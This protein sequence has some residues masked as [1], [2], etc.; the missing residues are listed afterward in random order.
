MDGDKIK[1]KAELKIKVG[2]K[3]HKPSSK[4]GLATWNI[5]LYYKKNKKVPFKISGA[6]NVATSSVKSG[7]T[8]AFKEKD[9]ASNPKVIIEFTDSDIISCDDDGKLNE[10]ITVMLSAKVH[11]AFVDLKMTDLH[12]ALE[13]E[14]GNWNG[15]SKK[16]SVTGDGKKKKKNHVA[17]KASVKAATK[18][19]DDNTS[20]EDDSKSTLTS[21]SPSSSS[22]SSSSND[23][24]TSS[25]AAAAAAPITKVQN[26][27]TGMGIAHVCYDMQGTSL[28]QVNFLIS[29]SSPK[30]PAPHAPSKLDGALTRLSVAFTLDGKPTP[31]QRQQ[32]YHAPQSLFEDNVWSFIQKEGIANVGGILAF[33]EI[34]CEKGV[35]K[36]NLQAQV[37]G[38][39]NGES[40]DIKS[41]FP[42]AAA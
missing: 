35:I 32:V 33:P 18:E 27:L 38:S 6:W 26:V 19:S 39:F 1:S 7:N 16:S 20:K 25:D 14:S 13:A 24:T 12:N 28:V 9:G 4:V 22:S 15:A 36:G 10:K 3:Q 2:P 5:G 31:V 41:A 23:T 37:T 29:V 42:G 21:S 8:W 34:K 11:D 17:V 30:Y 40:V